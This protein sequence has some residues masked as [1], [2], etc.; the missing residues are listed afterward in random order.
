LDDDYVWGTAIAVGAA[1]PGDILQ[2]RNHIVTTT[3]IT[4]VTLEDGSGTIE[5]KQS[6]MKRPHQTAIVAENRGAFGLVVFEQNV[7]PAGK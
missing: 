4:K 1:I 3:V 2:F 7:E 6:T 5:T